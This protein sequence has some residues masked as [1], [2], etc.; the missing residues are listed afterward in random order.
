[1]GAAYSEPFSTTRNAPSEAPERERKTA[2]TPR[3][4]LIAAMAR[5]GV[6]GAGGRIPWHL[7]R[8]LARFRHLTM[9]HHIVMG[10]RT[11]ES[12][13]R[14]LPGRTTVVVTRNRE[15]RVPGALVA[16]S[17][18]AALAACAGDEE[19]FVIGGAELY[20]QALPLADRLYLTVVE[21]EIPGDTYMP[22]IDAS[23]WREVSRE[24]FGPDECH[25]YGFTCS[26]YERK[27]PQG[28]GAAGA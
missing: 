14:P 7:P 26:V 15:L 22:P 4:S 6:I 3:I 11:Y 21:A 23:E 19:V 13:G 12:I 2:R 10:R 17:L 24:R 28:A 8:E 1:M 5:N 9:G 16:H 20:A 25:R 18:E 27:R